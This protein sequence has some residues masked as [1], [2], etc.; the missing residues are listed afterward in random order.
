VGGGGVKLIC[1]SV[2]FD[3]V[4]SHRGEEEEESNVIDLKR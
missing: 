4:A 1:F 2:L 3:E